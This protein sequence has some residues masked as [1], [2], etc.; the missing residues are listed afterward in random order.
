MRI[1]FLFLCFGMHVLSFAQDT[2][3]ILSNYNGVSSYKVITPTDTTIVTTY[4]GGKT[5]SVLHMRGSKI[6]RW[7]ENGTVSC[8]R[9]LRNGVPHGRSVFYN[10][11]GEKA[12]ELIYKKGKIT[13]TVYMRED[14]ILLIGKVSFTSRVN[15][16]AINGDGSSNVSVTSRPY[17]YYYMYAARVSAASPPQLISTFQSDPNGEFFVVAPLGKISIF[18][19]TVKIDSLKPGQFTIPPEQSLSGSSMWDKQGP[20]DLKKGGK[21]Q[22]IELHNT[23]TEAAP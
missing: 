11:K 18:P 9:E 3:P 12:A 8:R 17:A 16:G 15:G 20:F 21:V 2:L 1:L 14:I 6:T 4:P 10:H 23:S 13:D 5:E 22:F 7:Y 19:C